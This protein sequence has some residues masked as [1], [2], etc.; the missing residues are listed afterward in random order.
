MITLES[1][2]YREAEDHEEAFDVCTHQDLEDSLE[3]GFDIARPCQGTF[4]FISF[5]DK[6]TWTATIAVPQGYVL[7]TPQ[8]IEFTTGD[9]VPLLDFGLL[10]VGVEPTPIVEVAPVV[11]EVKTPAPVTYDYFVE[12]TGFVYGLVFIDSN[13]NGVWDVGEAGY[14]GEYG[15]AEENEDEWI[16]RYRGALVTLHPI[17]DTDPDN[18]IV[19]ESAGYR[20]PEDHEDAF[21]VCTHQDILDENEDSGLRCACVRPCFGTW[22]LVKAGDDITWEVWVTAPEGYRLTS[23][24]PQYY[25]TGSEMPPLDF[26]IT[27]ITN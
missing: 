8:I 5:A 4:G 17:G 15:V 1:A 27:P 2:G 14:G 20:E 19:L 13:L 6:V 16:W 7:T 24:N 26:G 21:D 9:D 18:T 25:T 11:E 10:P 12:G 22:G 23:P 3:D